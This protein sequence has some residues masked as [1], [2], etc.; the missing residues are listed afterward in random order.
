[1]AAH[2]VRLQGDCEP[3]KNDALSLLQPAA[4]DPVSGR[5]AVS[6]GKGRPPMEDDNRPII[7]DDGGSSVAS[8]L[9][10]I[11]AIVIVLAIVWFFFLSGGSQAPTQINI[12]PPAS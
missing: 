7:V 6:A 1:M 4:R 10:I 12:Q 5:T 3:L 9:G 11:L 2:Q 8:L